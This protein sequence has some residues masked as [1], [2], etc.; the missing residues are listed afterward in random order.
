MSPSSCEF[1]AGNCKMAPPEREGEGAMG[2]R[3][4]LS[5]WERICVWICEHGRCRGKGPEGC[6]LGRVCVFCQVARR[7]REREKAEER[8]EGR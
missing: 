3:R 6:K 8:G 1:T 5:L 2:E 7:V 4:E